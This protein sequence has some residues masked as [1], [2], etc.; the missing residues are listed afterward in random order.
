ML[1]LLSAQYIGTGLA[2]LSSQ[3][4]LKKNKMDSIWNERSKW[5][6]AI[7]ISWDNLIRNRPKINKFKL[8]VEFVLKY[9]VEFLI[10]F[11]YRI[12]HWPYHN[13]TPGSESILNNCTKTFLK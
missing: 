13:I 9:Y 7:N 1:S 4:L 6:R 10:S 2:S 12:C 8:S 3:N 5:S 11:A